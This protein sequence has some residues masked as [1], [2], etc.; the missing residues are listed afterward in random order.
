MDNS[1]KFRIELETNGEKV[2][3]TLQVNMDD[4][5]ESVA[6]AV[7]ETRKLADGFSKMAQ[8]SVIA[9]SVISVVDGLNQ[10]VSM[11]AENYDSFDEAMRA[12]NTMAGLDQAGF[13]KLTDQV[14]DLSKQLP[15]AREELANGLYQVIS[16][17]VP[18]D[19]WIEFLNK[20]ARASVGGIADL[21]ET[22][23][24]TSTIIKNYG[25]E[26]SAAGD[27]QD[28]IQMT[29]KNGVTSFEQLA[30]ALPRVTGSAATLG[31][32]IDELF[33]SFATLTG[34]TGNTAEVSTQLAAIFTALVKPSSEA[35]TMAQQMGIQF[36]AAAIKAA[37]G[38]RNFLQQLDGDIKSYAAA[39]GKLDQEIYGKLFGSAESLRALT[40]LTGELSDKFG[41]NVEAMSDSMGTIDAAVDNVAGS[42]KSLRQIISN[43]VSAFGEFATKIASGASPVLSVVAATT[44]FA[45]S[46]YMLKTPI[47]TCIGRI[48]A[49]GTAS[50]ATT[51]AVRTL[52]VAT[53][54]LRAV[55]GGVL[56]AAIGVVVG[57]VSSL[58]TKEEKATDK[59]DALADSMEAF[60]NASASAQAEISMECEKLKDLIKSKG[61]ATDIIS[62]LNQKYGQEFG[63]HSQASEWY[64]I[65]TRKSEAY[66]RQIAYEAKA[67]DLAFKIGQN[68]VQLDTVNRKKAELEK[69]GNDKQQRTEVVSKWTSTGQKT[70]A[71]EKVTRDTEEYANLKEEANQLTSEIKTLQDELA[72]SLDMAK[73]S[74]QEIAD[75]AQTAT[76]AVN[77]ETMSYT[78]L[79]QAI[80]KH[81]AVAQGKAGT[82]DLEGAKKENDLL[83][84]MVARKNALDK[85]YNYGSSSSNG[86]DG[87][88]LIANA[89]SYLALGNNVKYYQ[90][91]IEKTNKSEVDKIASLTKLRDE[92]Q[93]SQDAVKRLYEELGRPTSF[94]SLDDFDKELTY[95]QNQRST[96]S[97]EE[98]G[99]LDAQIKRVTDL[100]TA[101]EQGSHI[102]LD[103]DTV[104]SIQQAE[105]ELSYW[106][107]RIKQV[108]GTERAEAVKTRDAWKEKVRVLN[109]GTSIPVPVADL[110]NLQQASDAISY[111]EQKLQHATQTESIEIQKRINEYKRWKK[112]REAAL[113]DASKPSDISQ[114]NTVGDLEE[115]MSW[116]AD[117]MK[118]QSDVE[119]EA[120][121]RTITALEKKR[122]ALQRL[123][124]IPKMQSELDDL[125]GLSGRKL[126]IELEMIGLDSIRDKIHSLKKLLEDTKNPLG[127]DQRKEVQQQVSAW[128]NYEKQLKKSQLRVEDIWGPVKGVGNSI[129]S[130][131]DSLKS[132]GNAWDKMTSIIDGVL[133]LYNDFSSIISIV[134]MFTSAST[135]HAEAK[136]VE[137]GAEET[138]AATTA[139]GAVTTVAASTATTTA[140][141]VET[142]AWSAL[143]AAKTFA[144]HAYIPF[145]GTGIASGYIAEQ[146]SVILAAAIPKFADG[147]IAYGP[148]LGIFGEY[149]NASNNPEVVAPLNKLRNLIEPDAG[150]GG[151]V[152]FKIEGRTLVGVLQKEERVRART[153]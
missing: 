110:G 98:L 144:A 72:N 107:Q 92:A 63:Y 91:Q 96:A 61:D 132:N 13:E 7:G 58:I 97:Q 89:T 149:A 48:T 113:K 35:T 130:M 34:V 99:Q 87:K 145:A 106:E 64:D 42:A 84:K 20:S 115:A 104:D 102:G 142:A 53:V 62:Q 40:S 3:K 131:T 134:G 121:Q 24:V 23:T 119:I 123:A 43:N 79:K 66:C 29:A 30:Q 83:A 56:V 141:G 90:T 118:T 143:A 45:M 32:T 112:E 57:A 146:Q 111:Y 54:T 88:K 68:Q 74:Q 27:I 52:T 105:T 125:S 31:V 9:T 136:A 109:E 93:K 22:V 148:T 86:L 12:A 73:E 17:G 65:L 10:A 15:I 78:D 150:Y 114:L 135:S 75:S 36:D 47:S 6:L 44:Q 8:A 100:K 117:S 4:F 77:W 126:T 152:T 25:L 5:K 138:E 2:L 1:V 140:L 41:E 85:Q 137:A 122:D 38:M 81:T 120:T 153:R 46:L 94:D 51:G 19:N 39:H 108:G 59:T 147:G 37:G 60:K 70:L 21:G 151:K 50:V 14:K 16:N 76:Q 139:A 69:N 28:K 95:L 71:L 33:A 129:E 127:D 49:F 128:K 82:K 101:F 103:M 80:K 55:M 26:W 124:A 133:S 67:R 18:E 116:Y 11:L